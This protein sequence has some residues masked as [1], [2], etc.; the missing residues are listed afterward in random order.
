MSDPGPEQKM[1]TFLVTHAE[2]NSE[3]LKDIHGG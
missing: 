2:D 1:S 3:V